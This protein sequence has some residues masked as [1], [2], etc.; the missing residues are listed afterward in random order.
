[1]GKGR[2]WL[3]QVKKEN[4][5][6]DWDSLVARLER[7]FISATYEEDLW[8]V[9]KN[10]GQRK[11]ESVV[12]FIAV[13][14]SLFG[15]LKSTPAESTKVKWIL[16]NFKGEIRDKLLLQEFGTVAELGAAAHKLE[17]ALAEF[18]RSPASQPYTRGNHLDGGAEPKSNRRASGTPRGG[19]ACCNV[20]SHTQKGSS[21]ETLSNNW[22]SRGKKPT[23]TE[24]RQSHQRI[25]RPKKTESGAGEKR[26]NCW[27]CGMPNHNYRF[28]K[29][30]RRKF[31]FKCGKSGVTVAEC[32]K[33]S[34]NAGGRRDN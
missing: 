24:N 5:V 9:I 4:S 19:S 11:D 25:E 31:C 32:T 34:G 14:Q 17:E 22:R 1:M 8:Q 3:Q 29:Q 20:S 18:S 13:M 2:L 15:R 30:E 10:R 33:C 12:I 16:K 27:N 7:D 21:G 6:N 26:D 28:C 23:V